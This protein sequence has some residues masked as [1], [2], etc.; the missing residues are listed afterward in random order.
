MKKTKNKIKIIL[1]IADICTGIILAVIIYVIKKI[2]KIIEQ[3]GKRTEYLEMKEI[4]YKNL[5]KKEEKTQKYRHDMNEHLLCI[6]S[7]AE[8][9]GNKQLTEYIRKLY[10][11]M[12]EIRTMTYEFGNAAANVLINYY[13]EQIRDIA[14]VT[15]CGVW[16]ETG[17]LSDY[18][19]CIVIGN[20]MKNAVREITE[21]ESEKNYI[22]IRLL[23]EDNE[24][25][26][27]VKNSCKCREIKMGKDMLPITTKSD[28][29]VHGIGF[30]NVRKIVEKNHGILKWECKENCFSVMFTM[31]K[32]TI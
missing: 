16:L 8:K 10:S 22:N 29:K 14:D 28:K 5:L 11:D 19:L 17:E 1:L 31:K 13:I 25:K 27:I 18:D 15:V 24:I 12:Q 26:M 9:S 6:K 2:N 23:E 32:I 3:M 30:S 7:M 21:N 4:Y 20:L